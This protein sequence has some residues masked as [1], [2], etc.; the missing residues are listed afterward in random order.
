MSTKFIT[1]FLLVTYTSHI[2][3]KLKHYEKLF[4]GLVALVGQPLLT[5]PENLSIPQ[6][7]YLKKGF[8]D[9]CLTF[10][11]CLS[12]LISVKC[13]VDQ[14]LAF[15]QCLSLFVLQLLITPFDVFKLG[16]LLTVMKL[17][18]LALYNLIQPTIS[19]GMPVPSQGHYCFHSF[20]VVD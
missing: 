14:C 4:I 6:F 16:N 5:I 2:L 17:G 11:H 20:P 8:V 19:L 9:H 18:G 15:A 1:T 12:L 7:L 13:F 3:S 10:A